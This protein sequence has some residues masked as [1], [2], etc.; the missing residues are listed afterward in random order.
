MSSHLTKRAKALKINIVNAVMEVNLIF[1]ELE[2]TISRK[3]AGSVLYG[4]S[5][6]TLNGEG[7]ITEQRDYYDWGGKVR[8]S[9]QEIYQ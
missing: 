5:R 4:S 1:I 7:K 9:I 3:N 6:L 8:Q 2:R